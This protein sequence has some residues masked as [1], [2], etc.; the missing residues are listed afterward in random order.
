MAGVD[1]N[2]FCVL[3]R[4]RQPGNLDA[5]RDIYRFYCKNCGDYS[6]SE[7][8]V[9][10]L[11]TFPTSDH[12]R[13]AGVAREATD[14]NAERT[15]ILS[16]NI[17][18]L[19]SQAPKAFDVAEKARKLLSVVARRSR[20]PGDAVKLPYSN[21]TTLAYASNDNEFHY[22]TR[23]LEQLGWAERTALVDEVQL[24]LTPH[25]WEETGAKRGLDSIKAFVAMWFDK[26]MTPIYT[27]GFA[28]TIE[29]DCGFR[30]VRIDLEEHNDDIVDR[31]I[32]EINESRFVV[33]DLTGH[34]NGVYFEAGYGKGLGLPV[35][36]TCRKDDAKNSHFDVEHY[37]QIRWTDAADLRKQ[38]QARIRATIGRGPM[39]VTN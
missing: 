22:L 28:K 37:S 29:E 12:W 35:I 13:L 1:P 7:E 5:T 6:I 39:A 25:G 36:W 18:S 21:S 32:A 17:D 27:E 19:L 4:A 9:D 26:S 34:R 2:K 38:L 10:V 11:Q 20:S 14:R 15:R 8:A 30:P 16:D 33:A 31:V 24:T 23:Y 3:C